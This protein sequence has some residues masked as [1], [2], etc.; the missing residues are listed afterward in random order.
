[1]AVENIDDETILKDIL[2]VE[3]T[4]AVAVKAMEQIKHKEFLADICLNNPD[5]HLRL[6]CINRISDESLLS[7]DELS[8]LLEKMLLLP[9]TTRTDRHHR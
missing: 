9:V 5:S 4:S 6:A 2:N 3:L 1:M 8:S 7:K